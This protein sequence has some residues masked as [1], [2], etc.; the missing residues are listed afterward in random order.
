[1]K[2]PI[3]TA[4]ERK[5]APHE[6][7]KAWQ[8]CYELTMAVFRASITWSNPE[9]DP[10]EDLEDDFGGPDGEGMSR[11]ARSYAQAATV[12]LM[13]GVREEDIQDFWRCCEDASASLA[14]LASELLISRDMNLIGPRTYGELEALR[15]HAA[16]LTW[17]LSASLKKKMAAQNGKTLRSG[18][19]T[20]GSR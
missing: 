7:L 10:H 12:A 20:G 5:N 17:G 19:K 8:A 2:T 13:T 14:R 3:P 1:M 18:K 11:D 16:R 6:R 9:L 15:D 4:P